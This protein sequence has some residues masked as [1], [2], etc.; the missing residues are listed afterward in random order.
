MELFLDFVDL[1]SEGRP[2]DF[3]EG[4]PGDF[5]EGRPGDFNEVRPGDLK[6]DRPVDFVFFIAT[7]V[8]FISSTFFCK[9]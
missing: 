1:L 2:G 3:N 7:P 6:D 5:N 8:V 9:R 4:R